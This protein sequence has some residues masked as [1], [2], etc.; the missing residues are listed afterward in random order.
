MNKLIKSIIVIV[1]ILLLEFIYLDF[2]LQRIENIE[3]K[4]RGIVNV[5]R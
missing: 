5:R 4:E 1:I 2:Y 3:N